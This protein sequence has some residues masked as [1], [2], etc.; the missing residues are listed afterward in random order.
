MGIAVVQR[1]AIEV[2]VLRSEPQ[3]SSLIVKTVSSRD[4]KFL[5]VYKLWV[6][7]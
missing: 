6:E 7:K 1:E 3:I 2:D 4:I 5:E